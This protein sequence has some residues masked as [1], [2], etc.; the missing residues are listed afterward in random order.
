[1]VRQSNLEYV[2]NARTLIGIDQGKVKGI[3]PLAILL[4][5]N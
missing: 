5:D 3:I 2:L 1:M 4:G